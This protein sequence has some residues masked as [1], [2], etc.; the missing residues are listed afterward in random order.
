L[1][2]LLSASNL[3]FV[4]FPHAVHFSFLNNRN[5]ANEDLRSGATISPL[6]QASHP[7]EGASATCRVFHI[8]RFPTLGADPE[9][10]INELAAVQTR[11]LARLLASCHGLPSLGIT[12]AHYHI[13]PAM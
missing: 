2:H 12:D 5:S 6:P 10:P 13:H 7:G 8:K 9:I 11:L 1:Q 4:F 3:F